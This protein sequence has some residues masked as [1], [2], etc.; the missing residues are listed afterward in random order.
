[1][2]R[3]RSMQI[4]NRCG[5]ENP[6]KTRYCLRC[7]AT[8]TT[9]LPALS[10]FPIRGEPDVH[11]LWE[12]DVRARRRHKRQA[13]SASGLSALMPPTLAEKIR[14]AT[15]KAMGQRR[16]VTVV[17]LGISRPLVADRSPDEENGFLAGKRTDP[18]YWPRSCTST[19]VTSI[20][21]PAKAWFAC[22]A[23]RWPTKTIRNA[24][25]GLRWR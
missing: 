1:M 5:H 4:C 20:K 24:L 8:I 23:R 6:D 22:S 2:G 7:A 13:K 19:K 3:D 18:N 16:E 14:A 21:Y 11:T 17:V 12:A 25:F 15:A 10:P 9:I